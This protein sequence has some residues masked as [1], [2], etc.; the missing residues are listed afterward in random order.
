[1]VIDKDFRHRAPRERTQT[2][3]SAPQLHFSGWAFET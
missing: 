2:F 3:F 1:M